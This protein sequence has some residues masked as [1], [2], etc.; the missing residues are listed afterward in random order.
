M[1]EPRSLVRTLT[2][3][4]LATGALST[5]GL[6]RTSRATLPTRPNVLFIAIDDLN[7]WVRYLDRNDQ[8]KTPNL[9]RIAQRGLH[10]TRSYCAAPVC[11]PSR[12]AL[13]SGL[14]PSTSGV[15]DNNT[16]RGQRG[17]ARDH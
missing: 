3:V 1:L 10:F 17:A 8:V 2:L 13:M 5:S 16:E 4:A 15:Y 7:H 6:P 11:N 9:D 12:A 14:L